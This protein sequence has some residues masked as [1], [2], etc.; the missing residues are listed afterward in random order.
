MKTN[1][2]DLEMYQAALQL[3]Y[4]WYVIRKE[5][6][7]N[8]GRLD[9]YLDFDR[10]GNFPCATCGTK[11]QPFYDIVVK[12][13]VWRHLDFWQYTSF[14]HA[15]LPRVRCEQCDKVKAA[16]VSWS[17][18]GSGFTELFEF[19]VL[20]LVKEMPVNAA[21]RIMREHDTR[22]WR[23]LR[24]YVD[25]ELEKQDLS[26]VTKVAIDETS[27]KRGHQYV[28]LVVDIQ[29]RKVIFATEGKDA[30]TLKRF[31]AELE[32]KNGAAEQIE[33][34]CSDLSPAFI[35]G[36]KTHFPNANHTFDK[37]HILK[38]INEAVDEV[39]RQEQREIPELKRSRYVWLKNEKNLNVKQKEQLIRLKEMN[40]KTTKA[41]H[42]KLAFQDFWTRPA[43]LADLYL[44]EWYNWAVRSRLE[45]MVQVAKTIK[46]HKQGILQWFQSKITNGLL[47]GINSLVQA[48]KRK[49]RGY[50]TIQNLMTMIYLI[51]GKLEIAK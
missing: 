51:A 24:F 44:Q 35:Q 30:S 1:E 10:K 46:H 16:S 21:A 27:S 41:Y 25:K 20:E 48:A 4:P 28:S 31:K 11:N 45:P 9:I 8:N 7:L 17:R 50:R 42:L 6:D 32:T 5:F 34:F 29:Q 49:A 33:E 18:P 22:L 38:L 36:V 26:K 40:L 19:R 15:P 14:L 2:Q 47:E 37:F 3:E 39:R 13:R 12:E 43:L 23:T